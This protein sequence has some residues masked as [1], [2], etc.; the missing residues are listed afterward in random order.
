M[1]LQELGS[2]TGTDKA[3]YHGYCDFYEKK[4]SDLKE[5]PGVLL[6]LGI[7]KGASLAMWEQWLPNLK[8]A[9]MDI[10]IKQCEPRFS[11]EV[12]LCQVDCGDEMKMR[13]NANSLLKT[14]GQERFRCVIDDASHLCAHQYAA[15]RALWALTDI[16]VIEDIHTS[17]MP[18]YG[19][20]DLKPVIS[21]NVLN[22]DFGCPVTLNLFQG[23]AN[24]SWT[25]IIRRK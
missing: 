22:L 14:F 17:L 12:Y 4:L 5:R 7:Y 3:L 1:T 18:K 11:R 24:D 10:D 23:R 25:V 8:I 9:G 20:E 2:Q 15:F 6:E 19:R 21:D 16:Y 13:E